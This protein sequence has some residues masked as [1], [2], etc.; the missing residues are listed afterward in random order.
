MDQNL[1]LCF[2]G[3]IHAMWAF[4]CHPFKVTHYG[5]TETCFTSSSTDNSL[6]NEM[7]KLTT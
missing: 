4:Y 3:K 1:L 7:S 2:D 5:L 6:L